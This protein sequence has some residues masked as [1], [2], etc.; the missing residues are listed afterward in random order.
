MPTAFIDDGY[1]R[2]AIINDGIHDAFRIEFR[3][4]T[5]AETRRY[6]DEESKR[7]SGK[8]RKYIEE[9][10]AKHVVSWDGDRPV[11]VEVAA[12]LPHTVQ[13]E[14]V[15]VIQGTGCA[16]GQGAMRGPDDTAW[17]RDATPQCR[18]PISLIDPQFDPS[19]ESVMRMLS[20]DQPQL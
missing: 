14:I 11:N 9:F 13:L 2:T 6:I 17:Y 16:H 19:A 20:P 3:P 18:A 10:V 4:A 5:G 1:T 12:R 8:D 15:N 7:V